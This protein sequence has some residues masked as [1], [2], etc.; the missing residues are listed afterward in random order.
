MRQI[1][2]LQ[3]L[4]YNELI[5]LSL[6]LELHILACF[7]K[8]RGIE[9]ICGN[10]DLIPVAISICDL[11]RVTLSCALQRTSWKITI[12]TLIVDIRRYF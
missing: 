2:Q 9:L 1:K 4:E 3:L 6:L 10:N 8:R 11:Y 12:F 5:H 7:T